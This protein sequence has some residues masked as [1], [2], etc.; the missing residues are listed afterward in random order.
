MIKCIKCG[1]EKLESGFSPCRIEHS[2]YVCIECSREIRRIH[3]AANK[4]VY[5]SRAKKWKAK[6]PEKVKRSALRAKLKYL[7]NIDEEKFQRLSDAQN[8]LCAICGKPPRSSRLGVDHD[9]KTNEFRGLLCEKCNYG[10]G[11]FDDN[12][13]YLSKA[14]KYL[15]GM[16]L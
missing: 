3:Y 16:T 12:T 6:N 8:G 9:H 15:E 2:D 11:M 13:E 7:Y 5:K 1:E 14:I 4:D 10:L